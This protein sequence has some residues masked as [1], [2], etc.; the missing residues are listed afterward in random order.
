M[1]ESENEMPD[2]SNPTVVALLLLMLMGLLLWIVSSLGSH[3]LYTGPDRSDG[4][5]TMD[6]RVAS[7]APMRCNVTFFNRT[8]VITDCEKR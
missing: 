4:M 1:P 7:R 8:V 6:W 3:V 5:T 2:K